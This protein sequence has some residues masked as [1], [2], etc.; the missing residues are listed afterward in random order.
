MSVSS[1]PRVVISAWPSSM[2]TRRAVSPTLLC[3][4]QLTIFPQLG[5]RQGATFS[6]VF[7]F[8]ESVPLRFLC[9]R[10]NNRFN[11][12]D[13]KILVSKTGNYLKYSINKISFDNTMSHV[14]MFYLSIVLHCK[15]VCLRKDP[16]NSNL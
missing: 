15:N 2:N 3:P 16:D 6:L 8:Q 12:C 1:I 14:D 4:A 11:P 10:S 9:N 5:T 13:T 7:L